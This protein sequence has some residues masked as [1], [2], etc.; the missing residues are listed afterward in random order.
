MLNKSKGGMYTFI[1]YTW[2]VIKGKC[3]HGCSYCY[4]KRWGEQPPLHFDEK[5]LRT[6]L[7]IGNFIFVGSSCDMFAPTVRMVPIDWVETI[8]KKCNHHDN[9]YLIQSKSVAG[10]NWYKNFLDKEK[11]YICTTIETNRFYHGIMGNT[12]STD[13]RSNAMEVYFR[14]FKKYVT[15][16]PIMDFDLIPMVEMIKRCNP[17][18]VNIGADSGNNNLPGPSYEKVMALIEKLKG[19]TTIHRKSNLQR[20]IKEG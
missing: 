14:G 17:E 18:Q 19:F 15:I 20:L 12:V 9:K 8:L 2:N 6:D 5:E 10:M 7:G 13:S 1:D 4:M 3:P 11:Y 16:E